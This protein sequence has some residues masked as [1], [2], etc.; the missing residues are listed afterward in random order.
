MTELQAT[1]LIEA[2]NKTRWAIIIMSFLI[3]GGL[4]VCT[5]AIGQI[6]KK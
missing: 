1:E 2:I 3:Y 6:N 5:Y 4:M